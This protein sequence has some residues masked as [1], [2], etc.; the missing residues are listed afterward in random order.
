MTKDGERTDVWKYEDMVPIGVG[1]AA[2]EGYTGFNF[3][4]KELE[5]GASFNYSFGA[6]RYNSPCMKRSR[7]PILR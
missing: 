6:D 3:R 5:V 1:E 7:G 2:L 4:Y